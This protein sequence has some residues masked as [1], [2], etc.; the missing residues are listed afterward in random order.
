MMDNTKGTEMKTPKTYDELEKMSIHER[1]QVPLKIRRRLFDISD[2]ESN[3][4]KYPKEA[5]KIADSL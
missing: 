5:K 1:A 4:K 2:M 3:M